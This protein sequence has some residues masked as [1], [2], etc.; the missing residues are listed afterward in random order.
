MTDAD[1]DDQGYGTT[2]VREAVSRFCVEKTEVWRIKV[3]KIMT[4]GR[5]EVK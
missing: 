5:E 1:K 3:Y 2:S 4:G